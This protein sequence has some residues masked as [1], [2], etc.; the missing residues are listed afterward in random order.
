M[1]T[2][3]ELR[4]LDLPDDTPIVV[5]EVVWGS[6]HETLDVSF[7]VANAVDMGTDWV[8]TNPIPSRGGPRYRVIKIEG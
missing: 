6:T 2:L 1:L 7:R 5:D 3:G 8:D 4:K